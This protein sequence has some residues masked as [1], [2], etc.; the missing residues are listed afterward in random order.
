MV[1]ELAEFF[2]G[3]VGI[4][5]LAFMTLIGGLAVLWVIGAWGARK[6]GIVKGPPIKDEV[7]T[8]TAPPPP[9]PTPRYRS[10]M[11]AGRPVIG[12]EAEL[13]EIRAV[14]IARKL[15]GVV[16]AGQG[17]V[18]KSTV[19]RHYV[20]T[21]E[22]DYHGIIW[23]RAA[24]RQEVI[25]ALCA[26]SPYFGLPMPKPMLEP[27]AKAIVTQIIESARPWLIVFDNVE[28]RADIDG[29][30]PAGA[31]VIVT[32]RQGAGWDGWQALRAEVLAF[33][34]PDAPAV[35]LLMD[36]AGR[37]DGATDARALAEVLGGL[38]LALVVMGAYLREEALGFAD[39]ARQL[40]AVL[41]IVPQNAGYPS[42]VLG[43]VDLRA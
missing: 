20:E 12:R 15:A 37:T 34:T 17:G 31:H 13:A 9:P 10:A 6:T 42:S 29:L 35:R 2:V 28:D 19:G 26:V 8:P 18:G 11:P 25:D 22:A 16:L 40:R 36:A 14:M 7:I 41:R 27:D 39:G 3:P 38:P 33:D 4:V 21:F 32:T 1:A 5:V 24:T 30:V 23:T 43:A